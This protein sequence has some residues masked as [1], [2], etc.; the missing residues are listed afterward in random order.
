MAP[1]LRQS[2]EDH[3]V[4]ILSGARQVGKSTLLT[5]EEPFSRWRYLTLDNFDTLT[6]AN[7][8][9]EA[10]WAGTDRLVLDE[11]QKSP[12]LLSAVKET[13]DRHRRKIR[14][15]LSGSA[16]LLLMQ[17]ATESLAG[18]AVH[19]TL[20]PM[21][22]GEWARCSPSGLLDTLLAGKFPEDG[23][24]DGPEES[25][26]ELMVRGFFPPL[27]TLSRPS[28]IQGWWEGYIATYLERDLRQISSVESLPDFRRVM[29]ALAL[30]SA[31]IA[32]QT[33]I[34]RDTG[35][36]Q[37]TVHRY[38]NLLEVSS[39]LARVPAFS[40]NRTKRLIKSPKIHWVDPA[41]AVHLSGIHD[42]R[43]LSDSREAGAF[44][45]SLVFLHLQIL[46]G[47]MVPKPRIFHYRTVAGKEVDFVLERGRSLVAV[48]A[49][50]T[51]SP[52][53]SDTEGLQDFM[54]DYPETVAGLL[55]YDGKE[56]RRLHERI[57][58]VPWSSLG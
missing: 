4:V 10:L 18:R 40:R 8:D 30:R 46:T 28:G 51:Q 45:E 9:P 54:E 22:W 52:R 11:V 38:M 31:N 55:V 3:P 57:L 7:R 15:V 2:V 19:A 44:F 5:E 14:F 50:F 12:S 27:E 1:L 17:H 47:L 20:Y 35:V 29:A 39:L 37:A 21:S 58:A 53:Y 6:Q 24:I 26:G 23:P 48:E 13:V 25:T 42:A 49:K 33:E 43:T 41:L 16:N 36:S 56:V 32:N 34:A